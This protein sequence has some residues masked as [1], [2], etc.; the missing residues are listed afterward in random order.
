LVPEKNEFFIRQA[1]TPPIL[2]NN[3]AEEG[4][5]KKCRIVEQTWGP[6]ELPCAFNKCRIVEQTKENANA[7]VP[8]YF[9][10]GL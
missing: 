1:E 5:F 10:L 3:S 7:E 9:F 2:M 6:L 8:T 4:A